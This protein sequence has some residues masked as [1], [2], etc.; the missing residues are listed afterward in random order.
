MDLYESGIVRFWVKQLPTIPKADE[1][2]A[3]DK[4]RVVSR[5][6]PIQLTDLTSAFLVLGIG[7]GLAT[8]VFLLETI[9]SK[10]EFF[11]VTSSR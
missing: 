6:A 11:Y 3:N 10:W 4:R 2:F 5:P 1:C 9:Y 8:L 7:I